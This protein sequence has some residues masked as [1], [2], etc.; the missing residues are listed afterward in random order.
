LAEYLAWKEDRSHSEANAREPA[1]NGVRLPDGFHG[2]RPTWATSV[3]VVIA[4]TP[5]DDAER[6]RPQQA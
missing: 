3:D 2:A 6:I 1:T 4:I 5:T